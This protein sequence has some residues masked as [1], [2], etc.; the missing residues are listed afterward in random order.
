MMTN[1]NNN[2]TGGRMTTTESPEQAETNAA[3]EPNS[4]DDDHDIQVPPQNSPLSEG[5]RT[6]S[7]SSGLVNRSSPAGSSSAATTA[8]SLPPAASVQSPPS[9]SRTLLQVVTTTT[10]LPSAPPLLYQ[11]S[12]SLVLALGLS[13]RTPAADRGRSVGRRQEAAL[14]RLRSRKGPKHG[15]QQK[16]SEC[17]EV[18][19]KRS[20]HAP[21]PDDP[22]KKKRKQRRI[23]RLEAEKARTQEGNTA[24]LS[25][26]V[27]EERSADQFFLGEPPARS[28]AA[29]TASS[30][31]RSLPGARTTTSAPSPA[32]PESNAATPDEVVDGDPLP[33]ESR[34]PPKQR[35]FMEDVIQSLKRSICLKTGPRRPGESRVQGKWPF[36]SLWYHPPDM[37]ISANTARPLVA[38]NYYLKSLFIWVPEYLYREEFPL[39]VLPCPSCRGTDKVVSEGFNPHGPRRVYGVDDV[40]YIVC[41][42]YRCLSCNSSFNGTDQRVLDLIPADIMSLFPAYVS[43]RSAI[44]LRVVREMRTLVTTI[45]GCGISSYRRLLASRYATRYF[46]VYRN[47]LARVVRAVLRIQPGKELP[48]NGTVEALRSVTPFSEFDDAFGYGSSIPSETYLSAA[49]H[50]ELGR[51]ENFLDRHM[52]MI[53]VRIGKADGCRKLPKKVRIGN[54]A[55]FSDLYTI[56]NEFHQIVSQWFVESC[57]AAEINPGLEGLSAR[58]D[59]HGFPG[60]I[61]M[62][63]DNCCSEREEVWEKNFKS[64][65]SGDASQQPPPKKGSRKLPNLLLSSEPKLFTEECFTEAALLDVF[66]FLTDQVTSDGRAVIGFDCEWAQRYS[67]RKPIS[68]IQIAVREGEGIANYVIQTTQ[69]NNRLPSSLVAI[70]TS[71]DILKVGVQIKQD[72]GKIQTDFGVTMRGILTLGELAFVKNLANRKNISMSLLVSNFLGCT[73]PKP[74]SVRRSPWDAPTL[75]LEQ[76]RYA[77]LDAE[78]GLKLYEELMRIKS[79]LD[80]RAPKAFE[81]VVGSKVLLLDTAQSKV[82]AVGTVVEKTSSSVIISGK[83]FPCK[84]SH[85]MVTLDQIVVPQALWPCYN[86]SLS[87]LG[88]SV[89]PWPLRCTRMFLGNDISEYLRPPVNVS[90]DRVHGAQENPE[91]ATSSATTSLGSGWDTSVDEQFLDNCPDVIRDNVNV[92]SAESGVCLLS[93]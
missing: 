23:E 70:L 49:L 10:T 47:W 71:P 80:L 83:D 59:I 11:P 17:G 81:L 48:L 65:I 86:Y 64:L 74:D 32:V 3:Q 68:V 22:K 79:V 30:F 51:R 4:S 26:H 58:F 73:I 20:F 34:P 55:V 54:S 35:A 57:S 76:I 19:H 91:P 45:P 33:S 92:S 46:T 16:C 44:D 78:A 36:N 39:G 43:N 63:V 28:D 66:R 1:N 2:M 5:I 56:M 40:Y 12:S 13:D 87:G 25:S 89:V 53:D 77:A 8:P 9:S 50:L 84:K 60:F 72:A 24:S 7:S 27:P 31:S 37:S 93:P 18:G 75:S 67:E 85:A 29:E 14:G 38:E 15:S 88:V 6:S 82:I 61:L 52:Q 90:E 21:L 41:K 62:Y 69:W 42:R